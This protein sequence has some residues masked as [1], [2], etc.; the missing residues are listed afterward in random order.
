MIIT[1]VNLSNYIDAD[2]QEVIRAVNRQLSEDFARHWHRHAQLRLEGPIGRRPDRSHPEELRGDAILYLWDEVDQADALGYHDLNYRGIPFGVVFTELAEELGEPW[3]VTFSHEALELAMDPEANLLARG[4]HPEDPSR[5]VYH[6]YELC[7]AVQ[8]QSY[9]IDGVEVSNFVL[10]LYFTEGDEEGSRNDFLGDEERPLAS[11]GVAPGGYIGFFDPETGRHEQY[12]SPEGDSLRRHAARSRAGFTRRTVRRQ[13]ERVAEPMIRRILGT[14]EVPRP[15]FDAF[16]V[17]VAAR[18]DVYATLDRAARAALGPRWARDYTALEPTHPLGPADRA[19]YELVPRGAAPSAAEA[20]EATH[21][22]R[23]QPGVLDAEPEF[24]FFHPDSE[25][26]R[27][28][29]THARRLA[30]FGGAPLVASS[31]CDWSVRQ[32]RADEVWPDTRGEGIAIAHPDTGYTE[33]PEI[34]E[35]GSVDTTRDRDVY[36]EPEDD[37]ARAEL[38]DDGWNFGGP[39]HGTATASVIVGPPGPRDAGLPACDGDAICGESGAARPLFVSGV[40]PDAS[41]VP[42]R[43]SNGVV[44]FSWRSVRR[45]VEH[46]VAEDLPIVSMSLGGPLPSRR[47]RAVIAAAAQRGMVLIAA[48]G[49]DVPFRP[50]VWPARYPEVVA[51]AATNAE[52]RPWSGS[53]RGAAIDICAPGESVWRAFVERD[54]AGVTHYRIG[55]SSGTSYATAAVAGVCAL[56]MARHGRDALEARYGGRLADA[57]RLV[58]DDTARSSPHLPEDEFGPGIVDAKAVVD[59]PLPSR[60]RVD[61]AARGSRRQRARRA[62]LRG[63]AGHR[64]LAGL[65]GLLPA[66]SEG[67]LQRGV[68][69]LLGVAPPQLSRRLDAVGDELFFHLA[70]RPGARRELHAR[71]RQA[72][73]GVRGRAALEG[74]TAA[75]FDDLAGRLGADGSPTLRAVLRAPL[76]PR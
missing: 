3:T 28:L 68:A 66:L 54:A 29:P 18:G 52:R 10:P 49:N 47:T 24:V 62:E 69:A 8:A 46:A 72:C 37:D 15:R 1:V 32:I 36:A 19:P 4:P 13:E 58:L 12:H 43:V 22:L 73:R 6:W 64:V 25:S 21:R 38:E 61:H 51:C 34:W 45:A 11:F 67:D 7:D 50:V 42:L 70:T 75:L 33:H 9:E 41:V 59:H 76:H 23:R 17:E 16:S 74:L 26:I 55:R 40:A 35:A 48:A 30:L 27:E 39:G 20:W 14:G 65:R 56:W 60:E 63:G 53:S 57:F 31:D 71:C 44:H 5:S 2:V